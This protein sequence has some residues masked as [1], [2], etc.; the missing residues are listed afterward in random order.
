MRRYEQNKI[1][2]K[3]IHR[4]WQHSDDIAKSEF[5]TRKTN[6]W[7]RIKP[8]EKVIWSRLSKQKE[9]ENENGGIV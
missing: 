7:K 4:R 1:A 5:T 6:V 9:K 2:D 8:N 3:I